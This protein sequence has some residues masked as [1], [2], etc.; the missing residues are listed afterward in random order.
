MRLHTLEEADAKKTMMEKLT[1]DI[2]DVYRGSDDVFIIH[3]EDS[4]A[5]V[6]LNGRFQSENPKFGKE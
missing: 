2:T 5:N 6:M 4:L 3:R 1:A